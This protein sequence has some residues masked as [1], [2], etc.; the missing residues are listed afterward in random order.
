MS[1][2][3]A[4]PVNGGGQTGFTS[5][6]YGVAVDNAPDT[7]AKAW[8]VNSIGGTQVGVTIHGASSPFS[9]AFFRP[10][11]IKIVP[12]RNPATGQAI[13]TV[14][15]N[16]YKVVVLKGVTPYLNAPTEIAIG[17][18][19]LSI[20]AGADSYD[21]ANVRALL[22]MLIGALGQIGSGLGDTTISGTL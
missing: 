13:G 7:N 22:S 16:T 11:T 2:A 14:G 20:P 8:Y 5:P 18:V 17:R 4:S 10:K 3:L 12:Y 21:P 19:E 9:I 6:T 15:K 1:I